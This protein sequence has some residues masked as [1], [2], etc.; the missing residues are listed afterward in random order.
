MRRRTSPP[1]YGAT[2]AHPG[3]GTPFPRTARL[4]M[5]AAAGA[6]VDPDSPG[7]TTPP[8]SLDDRFRVLSE[9]MGSFARATSD[10][11]GLLRTVARA[12]VELLESPCAV[13]VLS[14][15]RRRLE[16]GA[17]DHPDRALIGVAHATLGSAPLRVPRLPLLR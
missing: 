5:I 16:L 7:N 8:R 13:L 17:L 6:L 1:L 3:R 14:E 4:S 15:D 10:P 11:R 12:F 9:A 2:E